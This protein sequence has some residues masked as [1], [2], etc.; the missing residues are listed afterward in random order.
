MVNRYATLQHT[1]LATGMLAMLK[2]L[3]KSELDVTTEKV[4]KRY[5][6]VLG[7]PY[8]HFV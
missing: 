1:I 4:R 8:I 6:Y 5:R 3:P 2:C 7:L